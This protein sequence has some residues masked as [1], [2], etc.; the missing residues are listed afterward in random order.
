MALIDLLRSTDKTACEEYKVAALAELAILFP[1]AEWGV[2][3]NFEYYT[4]DNVNNLWKN[5]IRKGIKKKIEAASLGKADYKAWLGDVH[6]LN[7]GIYR[8]SLFDH[9]RNNAGWRII[10][11]SIPRAGAIV[12]GLASHYQNAQNHNKLG[13]ASNLLFD[14]ASEALQS[15]GQ[16]SMYGRKISN[17]DWDQSGLIPSPIETVATVD[18]T[19]DFLYLKDIR[20]TTLKKILASFI[21]IKTLPSSTTEADLNGELTRLAVTAKYLSTKVSPFWGLE[22][23]EGLR[24][25]ALQ[26]P[27]AANTRVLLRKK[28]STRSMVRVYYGP[29]GTGKTLSAV[30]EA[31][32]LI[33]PGFDDKGNLTV[34][35]EK[36]NDANAA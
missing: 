14:I 22:E 9:Y 30:R 6:Y 26:D 17:A 35:F 29:P 4:D 32:K 7:I 27:A 2:V 28:T 19:P 10:V 11:M 3:D 13:V 15:D 24:A 21:A 18:I 34:S 25:L 33:E 8:K 20:T 23:F 5:E 12:L 16:A 1:E 36:F 31:I